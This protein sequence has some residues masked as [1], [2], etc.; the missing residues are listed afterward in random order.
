MSDTAATNAAAAQIAA[1]R[2]KLAEK[3]GDTSRLGGKGTER[4]KVKAVHKTQLNDDKKL[5]SAIKKFNVQ[6]IPEVGEVN[7]FKDDNTVIQ[8]KNP[9]GNKSKF[10]FLNLLVLASFA[11]NTFVIIG[12][13]DTKR[14]YHII[15]NNR[16][17]TQGCHC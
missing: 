7:M 1:A 8:F 6:P 9:E 17:R 2:A 11:S 13:N 3:F 4:R 15:L 16:L 10:K 14:K 5:K 12:K